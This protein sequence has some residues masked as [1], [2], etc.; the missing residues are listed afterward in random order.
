VTLTGSSYFLADIESRQFR[1]RPDQ[2]TAESVVGSQLPATG[3]NVSGFLK[4]GGVAA[5]R[6]PNGQIEAWYLFGG[7]L[8]GDPPVQ[9]FNELYRAVFP[10]NLTGTPQ[11][12]LVQDLSAGGQS[13]PEFNSLYYHGLA[14][15]NT[16]DGFPLYATFEGTSGGVGPVAPRLAAISPTTGQVKDIMDFTVRLEGGLAAAHERGSV[17]LLADS[18]EFARDATVLEF[19]PRNNY[20][21]NAWRASNGD[22]S[23]SSSTVFAGGTDQAFLSNAFQVEGLA[24]TN[25]KLT[26]AS[27]TVDSQAQLASALITFNPNGTNAPGSPKI[28]RVERTNGQVV[29]LSEISQGTPVASMALGNPEGGIDTTSINSLFAQLAYSQQALDSGFVQ[30]VFSRHFF[31]TSIDPSG[32]AMSDLAKR[33]PNVLQTFVNT[34]AGIGRTAYELRHVMG[35]PIA[36]DHPCFPAEFKAKMDAMKQASMGGGDMSGGAWH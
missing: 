4:E 20:L 23:G 12:Q 33:I 26:I 19:D 34:Q 31:D 3:S 18:G 8:G 16:G 7:V 22:L 28:E 13:A 32:C 35:Q 36:P 9:S 25:G 6:L 24:F 5:N 17:F 2:A 1:V 10:S 30:D 29:G 14:Y 21:K 15:F 11:W 27:R